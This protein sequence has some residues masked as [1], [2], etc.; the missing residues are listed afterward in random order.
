MHDASSKPKE[1]DIGCPTS[2]D[3][4]EAVVIERSPEAKTKR[5]KPKKTRNKR[6]GTKDE[7]GRTVAWS[8]PLQLFSV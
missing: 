1:Q 6:G 2:S 8:H 5:G 3:V 4:S 7:K